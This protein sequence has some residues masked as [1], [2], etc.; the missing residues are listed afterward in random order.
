MSNGRRQP[1][2]GGTSRISR[3]A[4]VRFCEGLGVKF[5]GPT[6]QTECRTSARSAA[7]LG[8]GGPFRST[9][10]TTS[11]HVSLYVPLPT[12]NAFAAWRWLM[13]PS[14]NLAAVL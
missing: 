12:P 2:C 5:P 8:F 4:Y 6:R 10:R 13:P 3:E 14:I 7:A 1:S 9:S 11:V